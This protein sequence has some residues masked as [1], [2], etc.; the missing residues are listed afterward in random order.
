MIFLALLK[1]CWLRKSMQKR[2]QSVLYLTGVFLLA[3]GY[4][5]C[6]HPQGCLYSV[7][8]AWCRTAG[9]SGLRR[10]TESGGRSRVLIF[11]CHHLNTVLYTVNSRLPVRLAGTGIC[12]CLIL[13]IICV[14]AENEQSQTNKYI[15]TNVFSPK[16]FKRPTSYNFVNTKVNKLGT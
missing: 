7:Q 10:S 4:P 3:S 1:V 8:S 13:Q 9:L 12:C 14:I 5:W 11:L 6:Y 15:Q 16:S 2:D